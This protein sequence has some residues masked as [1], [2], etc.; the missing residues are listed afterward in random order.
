MKTLI[1]VAVM[2]MLAAGV[3][4]QGTPSA[5]LDESPQAWRLKAGY[6]DLGDW[7][8]DL[9]LA[10]GFNLP[11]WDFTAGW[12]NAKGRFASNAGTF[13]FKGDYYYLEVAYTYR[14]QGNPLTYFGIG[15]GWYRVDGDYAAVGAA[16]K[17]SGRDD[18]FG[19]NVLVGTESS[20][21]RWFGEVRWV[22][23]TD[24]WDWNSD[25][26]RAYLGVRF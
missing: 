13:D 23:G 8:G 21:R 5:A 7:D 25:G 24:H 4:A 22:L 10:V 26:L 11:D 9:T 3:S 18:S 2:L 16:Q 15:G 12:A 6:A 19:L 14:P 20:D 1:I 17:N